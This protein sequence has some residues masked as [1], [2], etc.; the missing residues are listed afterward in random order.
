MSTTDKNEELPEMVVVEREITTNQSEPSEVVVEQVPEEP[1]PAVDQEDPVLEPQ[2]ID[3]E[4]APDFPWTA[5]VGVKKQIV[6]EALQW[7]GTPYHHQAR[8]KGIG[9]DCAQLLV[10]VALNIGLIDDEDLKKIPLNYSPEWN[11]HNREEVMLGILETMGCRPVVGTP[12]PG[13]II[14]FRVGRAYGHLGI[15][16]TSTEFVHAELQGSTKG[17]ENG[18]VVRVHM[19]GE[20]SKLEKRF[21]TFPGVDK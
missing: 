5:P 7:I 12:A 18:K 16:V 14:A 21:F 20:W 1:M 19:A 15:I 9:V 8:V 11:I 6:Q 10:G 3:V 17:S 4:R 2:A 13:D